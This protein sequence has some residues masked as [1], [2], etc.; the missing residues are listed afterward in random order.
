MSQSATLRALDT[1]I[2]RAL[3]GS[4]WMDTVT[5]APAS[6]GPI[7]RRAYIDRSVTYAGQDG[8]VRSN[9]ILATLLLAEGVEPRTGDTLTLGSEV[10]HVDRV[11]QVDESRVVCTVVV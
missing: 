9:T 7:V 2:A 5:H 11:E 1:Q 6:G 3:E 10:F 4:G 8:Q